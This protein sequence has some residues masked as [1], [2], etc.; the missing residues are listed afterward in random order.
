MLSGAGLDYFPM[1]ILST[2]AE[3]RIV[4]RN[5]IWAKISLPDGREGWVRINTITAV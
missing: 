1:F 2:G 3:V 5:G 4:A